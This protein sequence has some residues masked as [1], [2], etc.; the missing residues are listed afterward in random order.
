MGFKK[1]FIWGA[2]SA[3]YQMEGAWDADGKGLGIWD[4]LS[5]EPGRIARG[6]TG[7]VSCDHYHRYREDA[8]L[9]KEMGLKSYRFSISWPRVIPDGVGAVNEKGLEFYSNL[10][11]E[12]LAA[13]IE[14]MVTL[15]HWNMPYALY[16]RGGWLNPDSALW[17]EEFS[18][19][20]IDRL[21]DR[22]KYWLTFNEPQM[23]MFLGYRL[24][25]HA[26]FEHYTDDQM[27]IMTRNILLAHGRAVRAIREKLGSTAL[28]GLAPT[29]DCHVPADE[30]PAAIEEA[31]RKSTEFGQ[32]F[33]FSNTWWADPIF[34]GKFPDEA[35]EKFADR[36]ISFTPEEFALVSQRL[37]FY[38]YNIYQS[39]ADFVDGR[40]VN[41]R[42]E[43]PGC[44]V[45]TTGWCVTPEALYWA[46]RFWHERYGLPV[47]ITEN[48][49]SASDWVSLDGKVHDASRIDFL[50]RYL[51]CLK[52]A[53]D[54]GID[55]M[56]YMYWCLMDN[57]E[58]A[59]GYR[60]RYGLIHVDFR[61]LER[62]IKDSGYWYR[63]V[64]ESNGEDLPDWK[65]ATGKR[66]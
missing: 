27:L 5:K 61:T 22:V 50:G 2:A 13:G 42:F 3:A 59:N 53:A 47:L 46:T 23:F 20:V 4:V 64:I 31:Y 25:I 15:Y 17:F 19:V 54:E 34:F 63:S 66:M 18:K 26:P 58:W 14:P 30:S 8:A 45:T 49:M 55:V 48:G 56:G 51:A 43:Y 39:T 37:D 33:I 40:M 11:D 44:P 60:D 52:R 32:D 12:L 21:G 65:D 38:G 28:I 62:T 36:M 1:D 35:Y 29:G 6:E 41:L 57:L 16:E 9:M 10:V 24:G 7:D